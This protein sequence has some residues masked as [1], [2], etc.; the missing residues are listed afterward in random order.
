MPSHLQTY[1]AMFEKNK[2]I[3]Y[4]GFQISKAASGWYYVFSKNGPCGE[5]NSLQ[6]AK[7]IVDFQIKRNDII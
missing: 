5:A 1:K 6:G 2:V 3:E 4:R 7:N